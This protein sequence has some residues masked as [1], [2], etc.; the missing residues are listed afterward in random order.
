MG[1]DDDSIAVFD[2]DMVTGADSAIEKDT[3]DNPSGVK[4]FNV[5]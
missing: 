3:D 1:C 4:D 5:D 2:C